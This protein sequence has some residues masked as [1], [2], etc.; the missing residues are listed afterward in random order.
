MSVKEGLSERDYNK[1]K[2]LEITL[3]LIALFS[4]EEVLFY[5]KQKCIVYELIEML[6]IN[7][8]SLIFK[9][10]GEII[11]HIH[12][13]IINFLLNIVIKRRN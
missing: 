10:Q 7:Y 12:K 5:S 13:V 8:Y 2:S 11:Y 6:Y 4:S 3:N 9:I 1:E